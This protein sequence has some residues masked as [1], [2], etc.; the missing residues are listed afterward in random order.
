LPDGTRKTVQL[1]EGSWPPAYEIGEKVTILYDPEKP[2]NARIQSSSSN[3][4]RWLVP[5]I[6][7]TLGV[8]FLLAAVIV[9][10]FF[11][12]TSQEVKANSE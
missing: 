4:L 2:I 6:T 8:A 10:W 11:K 7:G 5:G 3:I 1:A 9:G 12:S